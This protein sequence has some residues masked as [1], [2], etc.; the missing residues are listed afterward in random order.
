M[1]YRGYK[2][3]IYPD[4]EARAFF[5]RC[6]GATR[7]IYNY[8]V[9][10]Y[11]KACA[12]GREPSGFDIMTLARQHMN[13]LAW[14]ADVDYE[15]KES[16]SRRFDKA[17]SK[18]KRRQ[19][20]RPREHKKG[21][22][23]TI[24][25]CT[26]GVIHVDFKHGL[27]QLPKIGIIKARLHRTF[28]GEITSATIKREADG[29]Y[30]ISIVV[31][32]DDTNVPLKPHTEQGTVGIDVGLRHLATLSN[33]DTID[34]PD[35]ERSL[36]RIEFLKKRLERQQPGSQ[37]YYRTKKQIA[38]KYHH[39]SNVTRDTHHKEA[40]KLCRNY[41]TIC[42]ETLNVAGM[43]KDTKTT[44]GI[45]FNSQ[46]HRAALAL[47]IDRVRQKC[48]D[49]GTH[50]VAIDRFE[51]T[52]KTCNACG[53]VLPTI[54]LDTKEWTCPVCGTHHD[55]DHNA[56]INIRR[57]GLEQIAA[58][59]LPKFY[60]PK[61]DPILPLAE[62][63]V[64]TAKKAT[65]CC[66]LR[67]VKGKARAGQPLK[68]QIADSPAPP[69]TFNRKPLPTDHLFRNFKM[70]PLGEIAGL[71]GYF[72]QA[73]IEESRFIDPAPEEVETTIKLLKA[74]KQVAS[75]LRQL[76]MTDNT[77]AYTK[78]MLGNMNKVAR[79]DKIL[80]KH[81]KYECTFTT[82][83]TKRFQ[84]FMINEINQIATVD[85]PNRLDI[86]ADKYLQPLL[87][88]PAPMPKQVSKEKLILHRER[89]SDPLIIPI[90]DPQIISYEDQ[91]LTI[92]HAYFIHKQCNLQYDRARKIEDGGT[93]FRPHNCTRTR[94]S[95]ILAGLHSVANI[96]SSID[97]HIEEQRERMDQLFYIDRNYI[98]ITELV[99]R[100]IATVW[101]PHI[102][103]TRAGKT[104][105]A[106][107]NEIYPKLMEIITSTIPNMV[108]EC[109]EYLE[110]VY[111]LNDVV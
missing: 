79:V 87:P 89:K 85:F 92:V 82:W 75:D 20:N 52:T 1:A 58:K 46:L 29:N 7:Y 90:D 57:K 38:R 34:L 109:A 64:K 99:Q 95:T 25:Y 21:D 31:N 50:F 19:A 88:K 80:H 83:R 41:D 100:Y 86:M 63:N 43:R 84:Q 12:A 77:P 102:N 18:F 44:G 27:I 70:S 17:L 108:R 93:L 51:P 2:Y 106:Y 72:V 8:C 68:A 9:R 78:L 10:E 105:P 39:L 49:T 71:T 35:M 61:H 62:G 32:I 14:M 65:V 101:H 11:D 97:I 111:K 96:L 74:I 66:N 59:P 22:R 103:F 48:E 56:A 3:R 5:A 24:S 36:N 104:T 6:F 4:S 23:P 30:Y 67:T 13:T 53:H 26:G 15:V 98:R 45:A 94:F 55:R 42:M 28:D 73:F 37:R 47:F 76:R 60:L 33:G 69:R 107:Y 16:A 110:R 81:F 40:V 91:L 54:D